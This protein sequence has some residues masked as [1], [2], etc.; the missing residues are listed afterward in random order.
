MLKRF[1]QRLLSTRTTRGEAANA[2]IPLYSKT[3]QHVQETRTDSEFSAVAP[4]DCF[5]TANINGPQTSNTGNAAVGIRVNN[6]NVYRA[7]THFLTGSVWFDT[8]VLAKKGDTVTITFDP[9]SVTK[10]GAQF[11]I[12]FHK[13]IGGGIILLFGGLCHA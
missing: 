9:W 4:Y 8:G 7:N 12:F 6:V 2:S 13:L 10:V 5:V 11:T 1:I 3:S